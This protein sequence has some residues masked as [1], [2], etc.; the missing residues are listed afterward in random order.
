MAAFA[1]AHGGDGDFFGAPTG[2]GTVVAMIAVQKACADGKITRAEVRKNVA[3][4][5]IPKAK[6]ILG[7]PFG[8]TTNGDLKGGKFGIYQIQSNGT[9]KPI[10]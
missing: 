2:G 5:T 6:S 8:F 9:Y 3:T 4:T 1:K 7:L 10:G